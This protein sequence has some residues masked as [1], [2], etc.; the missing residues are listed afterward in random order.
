MLACIHPFLSEKR[1]WPWC[2]L[3]GDKVG[4]RS[5]CPPHLTC[6]NPPDLADGHHACV[7]VRAATAAPWLVSVARLTG[8]AWPEAGG[9]LT[10]GVE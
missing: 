6:N 4:V 9:L 8:H 1:G 5:L 3:H 10:W 2:L 7:D